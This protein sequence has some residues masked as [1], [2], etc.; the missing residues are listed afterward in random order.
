MNINMNRAFYLRKEDRRPKWILVDA[1]DK[2]LGRLAT[3]I[4]DTLRGKKKPGYTPHTDAGDYVVVINAEKIK[5]TGD[6]L[7]QKKYVRYSGWFGGR[8][9][10]SAE[11]MLEKHPTFIVEHAVKGMMPKTRL[12]RQ[13]VKK[14]KVYAGTEHP[15]KAQVIAK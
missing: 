7:E 4:A 14:L 3:D 1:A 9:E 11:H 12:A 8:K 5:L 2:V 15:H 13:Q 10:T 6:K